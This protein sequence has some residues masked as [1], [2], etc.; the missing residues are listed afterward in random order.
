MFG[1]MIAFTL[2]GVLLHMIP[3]LVVSALRRASSRN[4]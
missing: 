4:R 1:N 3:F 2:V